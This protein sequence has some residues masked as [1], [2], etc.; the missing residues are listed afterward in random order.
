MNRAIRK[1][2]LGGSPDS[3]QMQTRNSTRPFLWNFWHGLMMTGFCG[4]RHDR[5]WNM[6]APL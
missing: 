6:V 4:T 3:W 5:K 1:S 2:V